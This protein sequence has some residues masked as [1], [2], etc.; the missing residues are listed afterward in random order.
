MSLRAAYH[1]TFREHIN[2]GG[3]GGKSCLPQLRIGGMLV[4][5]ATGRRCGDGT[6]QATGPA[7]DRSNAVAASGHYRVSAR[8]GVGSAGAAGSGCAPGRELLCAPSACPPRESGRLTDGGGSPDDG[9]PAA[10]TAEHLSLPAHDA[11]S[12][13]GDAGQRQDFRSAFICYSHTHPAELWRAANVLVWFRMAGNWPA[14]LFQSIS[15]WKP[16][17]LRGWVLWT[18]EL[19]NT[20]SRIW[21]VARVR[22]GIDFGPI[23]DHRTL[24]WNRRLWRNVA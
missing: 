22:F 1:G 10:A 8:A 16:I 7:L 6:P 23:L 20:S 5:T 2:N 18:I 17:F 9:P 4:L 15:V 13:S 19:P 14:R 11:P 12:T 3:D 24:C 21:A